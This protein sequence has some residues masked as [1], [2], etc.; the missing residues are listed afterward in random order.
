MDIEY[1]QTSSVVLESSLGEP[2]LIKSRIYNNRLVK[3]RT[4]LSLS[5]SQASDAIGVGYSVL[6]NYENLKSTPW[7][8]S[9][10]WK[11]DAQLIA[12]FYGYS[13]EELWPEVIDNI[14]SRVSQIEIGSALVGEI[15]GT[16]QLAFA[17][18]TRSLVHQ[19]ISTLPIKE[20]RALELRFGLADQS[21]GLTLD[22]VG[23]SL[24]RFVCVPRPKNP[25]EREAQ[26]AKLK[27][28][29]VEF[30]TAGSG[31]LFVRPPAGT[32]SPIST[33]RV[34][35]LELKAFRFLRHPS[36]KKVLAQLLDVI[37]S[38]YTSED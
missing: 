24:G 26:L 18:Q 6:L 8:R 25:K 20:R 9:N 4:E 10:E 7:K 32:G 31:Q 2:F 28:D 14:K 3:A 16:E 34:R 27:A 29:G 19:V 33:E 35:Q 1:L 12:A 36:R 5:A 21:N 22:Q 17:N 38:C 37:P 15:A 13:C 11:S 23:A 30:Y